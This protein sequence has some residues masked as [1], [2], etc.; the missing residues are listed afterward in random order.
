MDG[1]NVSGNIA[2]P[3]T[4]GWAA[5][6]T[7]TI[8]NIALTQGVQAMKLVFDT[9]D[10]NINYV[11]FTSTVTAISDADASGTVSAVVSPNPFSTN[12]LLKFTLKEGGKTKV[13]ISNIIGASPITVSDQYFSPGDHSL[14]IGNLNIP[15]GIYLCV[16]TSGDH[17][18]SIKIIKE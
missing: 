12:A 10:F 11:N 17:T 16:I 15:S 13:T 8:P 14:E 5:F 2:V 6:Q 4:G 3:N 9:G 18:K 1:V 7:V